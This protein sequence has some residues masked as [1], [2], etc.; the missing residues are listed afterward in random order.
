[1]ALDLLSQR[2]LAFTQLKQKGV[3]VL[4]APANKVSEQLVEQYL[5]LK[6]KNLI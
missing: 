6:A 5:Q 2:Q 4:D 1:V 3:F